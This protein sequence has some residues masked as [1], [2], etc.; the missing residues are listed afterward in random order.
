MLDEPIIGPTSATPVPC[1]VQLVL[2]PPSSAVTFSTENL[3]WLAGEWSEGR[4]FVVTVAEGTPLTGI[5]DVTTLISTTSEYY[6][7]YMPTFQLTAGSVLFLPVPINALWLLG[8]LTLILSIFGAR[9][10]KSS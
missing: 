3:E 7:G 6:N 10:L 8:A 9:Q 4:S 2:V 5:V 1:L